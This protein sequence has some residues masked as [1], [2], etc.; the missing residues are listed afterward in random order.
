M[1]VGAI[2][3]IYSAVPMITKTVAMKAFKC[4]VCVFYSCNFY[5][6]L[7][8]VFQSQRLISTLGY[9]LCFA[10]V[11]VKT[12][13]VYYIFKCGSAKKQVCLIEVIN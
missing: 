13:R 12:L 4:N 8:L 5:K 2:G 3:L 11:I 1:I 6:W 10:V 7:V 9:D